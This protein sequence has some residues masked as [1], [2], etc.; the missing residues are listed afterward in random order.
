MAQIEGVQLHRTVDTIAGNKDRS[1]QFQAGQIKHY[2]SED[3]KLTNDKAIL[4]NG[5]GH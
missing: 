5:I 2:I 4:N 1:E 3:H